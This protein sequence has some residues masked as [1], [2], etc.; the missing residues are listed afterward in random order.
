LLNSIGESTAAIQENM[1]DIVWA[2]NPK[3][4]HFKNVVLRMNL[5][6]T[7][8]ADAKKILLRFD[9]DESLNGERLTMKQR[10]NMYL[11]F[12][13]AINNATK[14]SDT[15]EIGVSIR[16]KDHQIQMN[17]TDHGK[18]FDVATVVPGNGLN[19][20]KKR[21][22]EL[23]ASYFIHSEIDKGTTVGLKF[24]IAYGN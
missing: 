15:R 23:H 11:F 22:E 4:D 16:K 9:S 8:M 10:K 12:K 6:A 20:F 1:S 13:E 5:F 21:A 3:N 18:G 2:V 7:E 19:S 14:Y 24:K 17:I